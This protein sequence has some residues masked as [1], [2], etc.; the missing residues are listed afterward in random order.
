[1]DWLIG[2]GGGFAQVKDVRK[3]RKVC[4]F[5]E[6]WAKRLCKSVKRSVKRGK[7]V[8]VFGRVRLIITMFINLVMIVP[9]AVAVG[10]QGPGRW[11][12]EEVG[13]LR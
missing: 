6:K 7:N 3:M 13:M 8:M 12:L 9:P 4:D 5:L 2:G 10:R 1:V 11:R